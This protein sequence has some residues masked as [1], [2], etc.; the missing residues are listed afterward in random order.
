MV[1]DSRVDAVKKH[2]G[3]RLFLAVTLGAR[4]PHFINALSPHAGKCRVF[5]QGKRRIQVPQARF[6]R[7]VKGITKCQ[8]LRLFVGAS[9][10]T[11]GTRTGGETFLFSHAAGGL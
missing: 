10:C 2:Q 3:V 11:S 8:T 5:A 9:I 6:N 7:T 1:R 4:V